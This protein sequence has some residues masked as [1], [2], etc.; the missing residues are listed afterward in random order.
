[1]TNFSSDNLINLMLIDILFMDVIRGWE[2]I[3]GP[4]RL[5]ISVTIVSDILIKKIKGILEI[6]LVALGHENCK[7]LILP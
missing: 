6:Y 5:G 4:C 1:M 7:W 2:K 3:I